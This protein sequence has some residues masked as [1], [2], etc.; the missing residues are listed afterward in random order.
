MFRHVV[1]MRWKPEATADRARRPCERGLAAA[2]RRRSPRSAATRSATDARVNDGNFDL[3]VV[4]DFDDVD[5][6]L[7]Y[8]DHPDHS[9]G[10]PR[11]HPPDPRRSRRGAA[12]ALTRSPVGSRP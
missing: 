11:A 10:D 7:V 2:A 6:Y 1:M 9:S 5:G 4:A 8:R 12:P 3:V